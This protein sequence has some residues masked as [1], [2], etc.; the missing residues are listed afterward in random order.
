MAPV[1]WGVVQQA[2]AGYAE[3]GDTWG[4][5]QDGPRVLMLVADGLG[6]GAPAREASE[7]AVRLVSQ[8]R[9]E[10]LRRLL[11]LCDTALQGTRGAA[12]GLLAVDGD[13]RRVSYAGVGNV[14]VRTGATSRFKPVP[15]NGIVGANYREPKVFEQVY[16]P[17]EWV[18]MHSDGLKT[19][20]DLDQELRAAP[21]SA[22]DLADRL[23]ASFARTGDDLT[24]LV[25]Q[26][27]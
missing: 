7:R 4:L 6:S 11:S 8:M 3:C 9:D 21:G 12:V 19:R 15:T 22:Q 18:V 27:L 17:G 16:V 23:A 20:F 26:L 2:K 24:V 5:W 14:E 25:C 1:A 10:P 13:E